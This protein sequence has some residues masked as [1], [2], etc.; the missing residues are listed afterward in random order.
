MLSLFGFITI[1]TI[2]TVAMGSIA[3]YI[4]TH[5]WS[6]TILGSIIFCFVAF[7]VISIVSFSLMEDTNIQNKIEFQ[8]KIEVKSIT[9]NRDNS[10]HVNGGFI[11]G[12]G[13]IS[14]G[15][16]IDLNYY[17]MAGNNEIGFVVKK[18]D[19]SI[20]RTFFDEVKPYYAQRWNV[21]NYTRILKLFGITIASIDMDPEKTFIQD[22]LHLPPN[23]IKVKYEIDLK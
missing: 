2:L 5:D 23:T 1:M 19:A 16:N 15:S 11:L 21:K 14:G 3:F 10:T 18:Y 8:N 22:E 12:T 13:L 9:D 7:F 4:R 17:V 20:T 6:D